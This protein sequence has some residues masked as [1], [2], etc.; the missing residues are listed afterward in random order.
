MKKNTAEKVDKEPQALRDTEKEWAVF[1][2][3]L[4][5]TH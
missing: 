2:G 1:I 5:K 4:R 3:W